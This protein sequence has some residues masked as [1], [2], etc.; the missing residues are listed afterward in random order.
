[1]E[2]PCAG[3][4]ATKVTSSLVSALDACVTEM[5]SAPTLESFRHS[6]SEFHL[7]IA[8]ATRNPHLLEAVLGARADFLMWRD[9]ILGTAFDP[10]D[11]S[12]EHARVLSAIAARDGARA[13]AEMRTHLQSAEHD[14]SR[15]VRR[16]GYRVRRGSLEP[17]PPEDV[18]PARAPEA[19]VGK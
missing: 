11:N 4:A 1:V 14:F 16:L 6:D 5:S 19:K 2:P 15:F 8:D 13:E 12:M 7:L 3:L 9:R 17:L 10:T 18:A